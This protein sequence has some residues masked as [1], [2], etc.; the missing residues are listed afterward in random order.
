MKKTLPSKSRSIGEI[1]IS[2][3]ITPFRKKNDL[4]GITDD[5][6]I[7]RNENGKKIAIF[8]MNYAR[9][10]NSTKTIYESSGQKYVIYENAAELM[11]I[12][13]KVQPY[14]YIKVRAV[15]NKGTGWVTVDGGARKIFNR[16]PEWEIVE[17]LTGQQTKMTDKVLER[18]EE[19]LKKESTEKYGTD[20][21]VKEF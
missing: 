7:V 21:D 12:I 19:R 1:R 6:P 11:E 9:V 5:L 15:L 2:G 10:I 17:I 13:E 8:G 3:V 18:M 20:F 14:E 16:I 4:T